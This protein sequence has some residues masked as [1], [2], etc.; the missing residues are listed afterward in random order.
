MSIFVSVASYCDPWLLP[1]IRDAVTKA[2]RPEELV[3]GV[4]DQSLQYNKEAITSAAHPATVRYIHIDAH[5]SEG[6]CWARNVAFS[7]FRGEDY[8]LQLD[9]HMLFDRR[10]DTLLIAQLRLERAEKPI[11]SSYPPAFTVDENRVVTR[12]GK[13]EPPSLI[14]MRPND[15]CV[16][17]DD[18][19][20]IGFVP[21]WFKTERSIPG[22]HLA[23]GFI[24]CRGSFVEEIPY[25]PQLFFAG[26]E[27]SLALRAFTHGWDIFHPFHIPIYHLYKENNVSYESQH[28]HPKWEES[29]T[30]KLADRLAAANERLKDLVYQRKDLGAYGLGTKRTLREYAAMSGIDYEGRRIIREYRTHYEFEYGQPA[31]ELT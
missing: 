23:G 5:D 8:L 17:T 6:A 19:A 18:S 24:F 29:R 30:V 31:S 27:Q 22:C 12:C 25:D 10:W 15:T 26:E 13:G 3:F 7:L 28:W 11:L 20:E 21:I 2:D 16:L 4:V 9:S 14:L 1:T